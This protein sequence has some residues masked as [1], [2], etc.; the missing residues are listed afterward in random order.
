[1]TDDRTEA[2]ALLEMAAAFEAS[3]RQ[4]RL[5]A[6]GQEA[7][8]AGLRQHVA[9]LQQA[10]EAACEEVQR[11]VDAVLSG[12]PPEQK[13]PPIMIQLTNEV[14]ERHVIDPIRRRDRPPWEWE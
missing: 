7:A 2:E 6:M 5:V 9:A 13:R 4:L 1:M 8:A 10:A 14:I 12:Q 3:S 11:E